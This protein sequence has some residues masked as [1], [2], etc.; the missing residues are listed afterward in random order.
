MFL[1]KYYLRVNYILCKNLICY[2]NA[3]R[4]LLKEQS[5]ELSAPEV[6]LSSL[7]SFPISTGRLKRLE[8]ETLND[9]TLKRV[10]SYVAQGW[11][12]L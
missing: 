1:Q 9:K 5:P 2:D 10:A 8:V 6:N 11:V 3:S 7:L 4:A 12:K